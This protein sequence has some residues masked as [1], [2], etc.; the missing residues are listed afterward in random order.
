MTLPTIQSDAD[1][2]IEISIQKFLIDYFFP[3][4]HSAQSGN[5]LIIKYELRDPDW[6]S[7]YTIGILLKAFKEPKVW[8]LQPDIKPRL[9]IHMYQD[10][11]LCLFHRADFG[12]FEK[13]SI[14]RQIIPWTIEW[15]HFYELWQVNGHIWLGKEIGHGM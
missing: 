2:E 15:V 4:I 14:A 8:V 3:G 5:E 13:I 12:I 6:K 10:K 9:S 7:T 1:E 11:S